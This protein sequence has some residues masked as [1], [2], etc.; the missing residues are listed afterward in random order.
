MRDV[1]AIGFEKQTIFELLLESALLTRTTGHGDPKPQ[2]T[3]WRGV[4]PGTPRTP[5]KK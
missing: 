1:N 5:D 2:H 4:E 3:V